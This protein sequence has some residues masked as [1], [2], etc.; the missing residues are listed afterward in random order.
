MSFDRF[1]FK[2]EKLYCKDCGREVE[3]GVINISEHW[4]NCGGKSFYNNLI[5]LAELKNG[6]LTIND[7]HK[8]N[9]TL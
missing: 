1:E 5:S 2:E 7:V 8:I 4:T 3:R 9:I 6:K